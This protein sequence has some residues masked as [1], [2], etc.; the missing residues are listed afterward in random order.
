V[1]NPGSVGWPAYEDDEPVPH[2]MEAGSPHARFAV[3]DDVSGRW[4]V[5]LLAVE[6]A[7]EEA[8]LMAESF[9]RADVAAALRTGRVVS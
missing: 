6:Y 9:G 5:S 7:W 2:R 8:A 3:V 4:E 1:V